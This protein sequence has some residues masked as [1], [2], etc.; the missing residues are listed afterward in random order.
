MNEW[1]KNTKEEK[2]IDLWRFVE[3]FLKRFWIILLAVIVFAAIG[4][5]YTK[6]C[7]TPMYR[8][9]FK[10][11]I[12]NRITTAVP[13][14]NTSN[15]TNTGDLNASIGMMY[16]YDEVINSRSVLVA[17]AQDVGLDYGYGALS[18]MI[19]TELPEKAS[20]IKVY[21]SADDPEM[22][23]KLAA[24]IADRAK[25]RGQELEPRSS[26]EIV[27]DPV[28]PTSPYEPQPVKKAIIF[29]L[30]G[31]LLTYVF[32]VILDFANDC[33]KDSED[34]ENRYDV[35]V[36]GHIP[37]MSQTGKGYRYSYHYT[38]HRY[39]HGK[40]YGESK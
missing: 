3:I 4:F 34:L 9:H 38:Y 22:A 20:L 36:V 11:Y 30:L 33:V 37:D 14:Q 23:V 16:L 7:V 24:A 29:A 40:G 6:F 35:V 17:A 28:A 27:D 12:K 25:I 2:E 1:Q 19:S 13:E 5:T 21:V 32:F 18:G 39:Q 26:M 10:A 31:G 8:T 15:S